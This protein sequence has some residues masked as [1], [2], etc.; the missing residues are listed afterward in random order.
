MVCYDPAMKRAVLILWVLLAGCAG[1]KANGHATSGGSAASTAN[2]PPQIP[3]REFFRNPDSTAYS[4]SPDGRWISF[5]QPYKVENTSRMNVFV[6]KRGEKD[7]KRVSSVTDR[8]IREYFWKGN[9]YLLFMKDNG[10]DENFHL[11]AVDRDGKA[12]RELTPFEK[13]RVQMVDELREH[14]TDVIIEMNKRDPQVFDAYRVNVVNGEMK[15]VAQNPGNIR[16]WITD[17]DGKIRAATTSDGVNT[18]LMVRDKESDPFRTIV[19][20]NFKESVEP[21][22]FTFDN[23]DLYVSTN[24]GRD[25]SEIAILD[26]KTGKERETLFKHADVD[27]HQLDYSR[28][29]KVL[30]M[31]TYTTWKQERTIFDAR[32]KEIFD[33]LAAKLPGY[34]IMITGNNRDED[35]LVVATF[36]DRTR[37]SRYVYDANTKA[38][39]KLG[40]VSP[41]LNESDMA[42]MKPIQYPTR[43]GLTING[44]LTVPRGKQAK[45]LPVVVNPHGGPWSRNVWSFNPEVQ[46][47]ANRG[48]AVLQM[49]FRGS[50]GYGRKFW[51]SSFKEW[52]KKMQDDVTDG[53]QW[54]V[55]EGVADPKRTCIYGGS[56]G[57]YATLAGVAFTPDLYTCA[58]DYVGVSNLLTFLKTIPPYWKPF[59]EMMYEMVGN[60]EKDRAAME[61]TSPV[62]HADQIRTPLLVLQGAKDPRVNIEES[63]QIVNALKKRG[64]DVEYIV[65]D[66][67]GH[68]FRNEENRFDA[69]EAMERFFAKY[70]Q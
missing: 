6:L 33:D 7:A 50:T 25:K 62:F 43:D 57:G 58:V 21:L 56:Y 48:Y 40:D 31:A 19:S 51:E 59:L 9:D 67:E 38:L 54:L 45:G 16:S 3:V 53:V 55:K 28:K 37:G 44:Y 46:W 11:F 14:D 10:G 4:V 32:T 13:T 68:G 41:W 64:I 22:F 29:R 20:T 49:N 63:N 60:P 47:L 1:G 12:T 61:A 52:G 8:D 70:L 34:E 30:T 17:H 35:V 36:N 69:Y 65:K 26:T 66:N 24:R 5:V 18:S 2:P 15:M 23:Q 42:E 27:V 39:T